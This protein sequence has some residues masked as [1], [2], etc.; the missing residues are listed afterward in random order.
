MPTINLLPWRE[1]L[2]EEQKRQFFYILG[3]SVLLCLV[4]ILFFHLF[5]A[6]KIRQQRGVNEYLQQHIAVLDKDI[7]EIKILQTQKQN[8]LERMDI[9]Q[10]LQMNRPMVVRLFDEFVRILPPGIFVTKVDR[11]ADIITIS[12]KAE[13]NT[14]VSELMRNI[15]RSDWVDAPMLT[16]IKNDD[17]DDP[18]DRT[19]DFELQ[20]RQM[21]P[22][23]DGSRP[24]SGVD[25]VKQR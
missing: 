1:E 7:S 15:E 24:K 10:Q 17:E 23:L 25:G 12:G 4:I 2:R 21:I 6:T 19:R 11:K 22:H 3:A 20:F 8:I 9:I 16:E 5:F 18:D 13:S 14:R